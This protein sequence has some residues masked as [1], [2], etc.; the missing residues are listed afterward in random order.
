MPTML[1]WNFTTATKNT[2]NLPTP[3]PNLLHWTNHF[4]KNAS[5][6]WCRLAKRAGTAKALRESFSPK[7]KTVRKKW[8]CRLRVDACAR[9]LPL[10]TR[11]PWYTSTFRITNI[12]TN[13]CK[14]SNTSL[15]TSFRKRF[16]KAKPSASTVTTAQKCCSYQ[17]LIF[18]NCTS[19]THKK[20]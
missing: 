14:N 17:R 16:P 3:A 15:S 10:K 20:P 19:T 4:L 12:W 9:C 13:S 6:F 5:S 18:I 11:T 2:P 1:F 7:K 8:F